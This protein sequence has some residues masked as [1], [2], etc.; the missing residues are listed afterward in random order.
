MTHKTGQ[1]DC[2]ITVQKSLITAVDK[3]KAKREKT[4]LCEVRTSAAEVRMFVT[5]LAQQ[6]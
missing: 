1:G 2:S 5:H 6:Q 3:F 4:L